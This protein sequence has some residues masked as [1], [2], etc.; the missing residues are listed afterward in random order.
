MPAQC[1][2]RHRPLQGTRKRFNGLEEF[3]ICKSVF[4][5][6]AMK[7]P[8]A[9]FLYERVL[10][11]GQLLNRLQDLGYRVQTLSGPL[12]LAAEAQR[13][14]PLLVIVDL[15]PKGLDNCQAIS[16][17]RQNT[18]TAHIPV[19]AIASADNN[20]LQNAARTAG[21]TL[22]VNDQAILVHLDQLLEQALRVD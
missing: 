9:L 14:K 20:N 8:L 3:A 7:Q 6:N 19:I 4:Q 13:E 17:L 1:S 22:V 11:G 16:D 5:A 2:G 21:A 12:Q 10:P 15:E 18:E